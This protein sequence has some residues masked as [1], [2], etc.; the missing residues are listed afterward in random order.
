MFVRYQAAA[1]LR[2]WWER[3]FFSFMKS[4]KDFFPVG[5]RSRLLTIVGAA[6]FARGDLVSAERVG[7]TRPLTEWVSAGESSLLL[8]NFAQAHRSI[9][10]LSEGSSILDSCSLMAFI[11]SSSPVIG[12]RP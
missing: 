3:G 1:R 7:F 4:A 6:T 5:F 9:R 8:P 10:I 11:A 2:S 12:M